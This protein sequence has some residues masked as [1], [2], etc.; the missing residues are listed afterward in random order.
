MAAEARRFPRA[1]PVEARFAELLPEL[2]LGLTPEQLAEIAARGLTPKP[3]A[4][5]RLD[6]LH[7]PAVSVREQASVIVGRLRRVRSASFRALVSDAE[8]TGVL[9]ARFLAVLEL[10][11][12]GAV[13]FDQVAAFGDLT[14]RWTG[15]DEGEVSVDDEFD[16]AVPQDGPGGDVS[17]D[18]VDDGRGEQ[19]DG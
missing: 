12:E 7:A 4:S 2:V 10:F 8:N 5:V 11:R 17:D 6:H 14:I 9:V 3:P 18:P 1:V 13:A 15:A 16:V 19:D